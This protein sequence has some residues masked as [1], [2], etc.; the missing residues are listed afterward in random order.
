MKQKRLLIADDN[1]GVLDALKLVL[2]DDFEEIMVVSNPNVIPAMVELG[3][4]DVYL[5]D[6]NFSAGINSGNE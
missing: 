1:K 3:N 6:M 5:L 4:Y 2:E